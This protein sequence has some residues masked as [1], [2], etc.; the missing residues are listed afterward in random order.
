MESKFE[1]PFA[2]EFLL[3]YFFLLPHFHLSRALFKEFVFSNCDKKLC[4]GVS[5]VPFHS[6]FV[7]EDRELET[8][9]L[10]RIWNWYHEKTETSLKEVI[11]IELWPRF[12]L[13]R[14]LFDCKSIRFCVRSFCFSPESGHTRIWKKEGEAE[15]IQREKCDSHNLW[16]NVQND[17][18]LLA[19]PIGRILFRSFLHRN[20]FIVTQTTY[21]PA[22]FC[23]NN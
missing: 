3:F 21:W 23:L 7:T 20:E 12:A 19:F 5:A 17:N 11:S 16:G 14:I 2:I 9:L 6:G 8:Y 1:M 10:A 15:K 4:V 22:R 13:K 18:N